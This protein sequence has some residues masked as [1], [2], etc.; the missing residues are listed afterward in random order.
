MSSN[1]KSIIIN[2]VSKKFALGIKRND[3]LRETISQILKF[4]N[5]STNK[6]FW[7]LKNI[8]LEIDKGDIVA[9]IGKNGSGKST[10]LKIL[11]KITK[12]TTGKIEIYGK[13]S[14]LLE[15]GT[16]F[17]P[18]L[19]G[20]EN[21]FLNGSILGMKKNEIKAK[22]DEI[23]AFA[24]VENFIDTPV[25]RYSSGMYVRLAFAV[26]AHLE[27]DILI[28]DEVLAVGDAEFQRKCIG[29]LETVSKSDGRTVLF[30][31]HNMPVIQSLCKTG[32]HL[33][34]GS[35]SSVGDI[36]S[37]INDYLKT[38]STSKNRNLLDIEGR[39]GNGKIYFE[40]WFITN[41]KNEVI[42][43]VFSGDE[44]NFNLKYNCKSGHEKNVLFWVQILYN[45]YIIFTAHNQL[46]GEYFTINSKSGIATCKIY[47]VPFFSGIYSIR[48]LCVVN[49]EIADYIENAGE[50]QIENGDFYKTGRL[51]QEKDGILLDHYW[52]INS[53]L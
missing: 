14:S 22:L 43:T 10:L 32:V 9:I 35:I 46:T 27:P 50:F 17:H 39:I 26:S 40:E 18:E 3:S 25:K 48:L 2:N 23:I 16:G 52:S 5:N 30:V 6:E 21:I 34:N 7:A 31:S 51:P 11:S 37:V 38:L 12:P 1:N 8:D 44:I 41:H 29:K 20:R 33:K 53:K 49:G 4:K 28:I 36:R 45:G 13:I 15:V 47:K 19:T 42:D 24:G